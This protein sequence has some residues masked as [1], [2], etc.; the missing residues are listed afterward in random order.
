MLIARVLT[1]AALFLTGFLGHAVAQDGTIADKNIKV[2][3]FEDL[4]Y[5]AVAG[6]ANIQGVV[7]VRV[8]LDDR[9]EV[10]D[11]VAM[12]G[13]PILVHASVEN[14]KK[15]RFEPNSQKAVIIVYNFRIEG[16]CH[17]GGWSSQM[18][19]RPPNFAQVTACGRTTEP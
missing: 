8:K 9:G 3:S 1:V 4:S 2:V 6:S 10:L 18:I 5:P 15:W 11:A 19:L 12:S 17:P 16:T 7:V 14:A 13:S